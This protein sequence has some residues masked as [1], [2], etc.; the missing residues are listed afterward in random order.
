MI[1]GATDTAPRREGERMTGPGPEHV[2][3]PKHDN[4]AAVAFLRK[5]SK[6]GPWVLAAIDPAK[7][8]PIKGW[9]FDPGDET[10]LREVLDQCAKDA[11]GVYF[12]VNTVIASKF[13]TRA[14]REGIERVT[15]FHVDIDP[16]A[17]EDLDAERER[18]KKLIENPPHGVPKPSVV[19]FSGGGYQLFWILEESIEIAGDINKAEAAKLYNL[20]LEFLYHGDNCHDVPRVMRLPGTI[21]VPNAKKIDRGQSN[22]LAKV[23]YFDEKLTYP[24][25]VFTAAAA[26]NDSGAASDRAAAPIDIGPAER[27]PDMDTINSWAMA[28]G[29]GEL[30]ALVQ[31][32]IAVG[33]DPEDPTRYNGD[34]SRALFAATCAMVRAKLTNEQMLGIITDPT[35]GISASVLDKG[36]AAKVNRYARKQIRDA[37]RDVAK[38]GD[39]LGTFLR[40]DKGQPLKTGGNIALA[41]KNLGVELRRN[42]FA[43]VIEAAGDELEDFERVNGRL[44]M[45][46][47]VSGRILLRIEEKYGF[48]PPRELFH[49]VLA[50]VAK[51]NSYHPVRDLLAE[52][53]PTWDGEKRIDTWLTDLAGAEDTPLHRAFARLTLVAAVRRVRQPGCKKDEMLVL[54]SRLQGTEKST[55][56]KILAMRDEWFSDSFELNMDQKTLIE[57]TGGKWIIEPGELK[58]LGKA[59]VE[60]VRVMLARGSDTARMAYAR[61]SSEVPRQSIFISTTN[62]EE[63]YLK[64]STGNRR[65]WPVKIKK[66]DLDK[67][68]AVREQLWAEAAT[69]EAAG[70]SIRL[71]ESLWGAAAD[72]QAERH[73]EEPWT[74]VFREWLGDREGVIPTAELWRVLDIEPAKQ[75]R[76]GAMRIGQAMAA[77]G[78]SPKRKRV[79]VLGE[80]SGTGYRAQATWVKGDSGIVICADNKG[81]SDAF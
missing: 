19:I 38:D 62:A 70:E 27:A 47:Q 59:H 31:V 79:P 52:L 64:D 80:R 48:L 8:K 28:Q 29:G 4:D 2:V 46:D 60:D 54:E 18:I 81:N 66:F 75:D 67:L 15:H 9:L 76:R 5:W 20:Q 41:T 69:A 39:K 74:G 78:W 50:D 3:E 45:S 6:N 13:K 24:L 11:L 26:V 12:S 1:E 71:D 63:G 42:I 40:G 73:V 51:R 56:L 65:F 7:K 72:A 53:Q 32:V 35:W 61:Y 22:Q 17:G 14:D 44:V 25:S 10:A 16:R 33:D 23:V 36:S 21:N 30:P 43:G 77:L 37:R 55:A 34:R 68:M 58:G 57:T 49:T